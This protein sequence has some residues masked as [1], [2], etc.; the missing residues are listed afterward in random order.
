[1]AT[2]VSS[3]SK[4][5]D[6]LA[7]VTDHIDRIVRIVRIVIGIITK[8]LWLLGLQ[9]E[10]SLAPQPRPATETIAVGLPT[11]AIGAICLR[12]P[13]TTSIACSDLSVRRGTNPGAS[14]VPNEVSV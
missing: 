6:G 14:C 3:W 8:E 4:N 5:P 10:L 9:P 11:V 1:M 7:L 12:A 13:N 2:A